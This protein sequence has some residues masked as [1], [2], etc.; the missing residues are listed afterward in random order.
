MKLHH[1]DQMMGYLTRR[2]KFSN[3]GD[4]ILPKPNPLSPQERNQKVF[5]DYVG[6][7]K[8]YLGAGVN[9]PEWFVKDLVTKKAE[10]LG[11]ELKADGGRIHLAKAGL[12]DPANNIVKGQDLGTGIQQVKKFKNI[13]YVTSAV[14][15]TN[16]KPFKTYKDAKAFRETLIKKYKIGETKPYEGKHNY[17]ELIKDKDFEKF[18]KAKVD[19]LKVNAKDVDSILK[20]Q[21]STEALL[22]VIKEHNLKPNDYEK[23]FNKALDEARISDAVRKNQ[24]KP[25]QKRLVSPRLVDNLMKTFNMS[26]KPTLGTIDTK[27]MSKLLKLP[28]GELEKLMTFIDKPYSAETAH[29]IDS[30]II[31]RT[32]KASAV[33][34]ILND[35]GI[36]F[37]KHGRGEIGARWRFGLD[38]DSKKFKN[39]EKS[40]TF[41]FVTEKKDRKY[42]RNYK[43]DLTTMSKKSPEYL[44]MGYDKDRGAVR[45][46][47]KA[48]NNARKGMSDVELR[49]FVKDNPKLKNLVTVKFDPSSPNLFINTPL[50]NMTASEI[51]QNLQF[52]T[53]HIQGRSTVKY[54]YATKKILDGLGIK[55]EYPKNL[56]IIPKALNMSTKQR[57]EN[58][59]A[60][61][62]NDTKTIKKIDTYFKDNK[63]S[64]FNRN[65]GTYSGAKP[66]KS[67]VELGHLGITK[68]SEL[69]KLL[70]GTYEDTGGRKKPIVK[71]VN[72]LIIALNEQNKARGGV[73]LIDD[74]EI[75]QKEGRAKGWK[76]N[77]FAAVLDFT[78]S[79]QAA[80]IKLPPAV[81]Q[82][83]SRIIDMGGA[84]LRGVGKVALVLDPIF[85]GFDEAR[86]KR[87]GAGELDTIQYMG[88]AFVEGLVNLPTVVA[89]AAKWTKDKLT[90]EGKKAGPFDY[91]P[92]KPEFKSDI[93]YTPKTFAQ[94]NLEKNLKDTSMDERVKNVE[95]DMYSAGKYKEPQIAN[96]EYQEILESISREDI[97]KKLRHDD[98]LSP[99]KNIEK[100]EKIEKPE[101]FGIYA[102]QIKNLEI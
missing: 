50:E 73:S 63:L 54:D 23:I 87:R 79:M 99:Y 18:W 100:E 51:R 29:L 91:L 68:T 27:T 3:G 35:A 60:R 15:D 13:R 70:S 44:E 82:A 4:A 49:A 94:E 24:G 52:E 98:E 33:K 78:D 39:L 42:P 19:S 34:K 93:L 65:T 14:E 31:S 83:A 88:E 8:K 71:N 48:L 102:D 26:Y 21:G 95:W 96:P 47:T 92:T 2:Q 9:M 6:R 36:T 37:E 58:F 55:M 66:S 41:G 28:Q 45:Q 64:Y 61:H 69:K 80:G 22:K 72:K 89:G 97:E 77:S 85:M 56:Y 67:A 40:K 16:P 20:G 101:K 11:V 1:Y 30:D 17:Q 59:V 32:D 76:L 62:P 84:T 12:A 7:M 86:A 5:N 74:M 81:T 53:D 46:L 75:I 25:G 10:E 57:V 38:K 90:G 43:E